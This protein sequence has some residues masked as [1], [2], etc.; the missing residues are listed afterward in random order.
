MTP[1]AERISPPAIRRRFPNAVRVAD[2]APATARCLA[3]HGFHPANTIAGIA[4]CRDELCRPFDVAIRDVWGEAYA[5]GGLAGMVT[6]G[7][8]GL[9]SLRRHAPISGGRARFAYFAM[10]HMGLADDG[11]VGTCPRAGQT[12]R[13]Q[14]CCAII[15]LQRGLRRRKSVPSLDPDD[16]EASYLRHRLNP[17]LMP[18]HEHDLVGLTEI[19]C[20][21]IRWDLER[22]VRQTLADDAADFALFSGILLHDAAHQT[23]VASRGA[24]ARVGGVTRALSTGG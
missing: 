3:E 16:L 13:G 19:V 1:T 18:S 7:R 17:F 15:H 9:G 14:A 8:A 23:W 2:Y 10:A 24:F 20:E 5:L 22:L 21:V 12:E 11:A 4:D 6:A